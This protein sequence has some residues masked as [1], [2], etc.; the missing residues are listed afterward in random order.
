MGR[1]RRAES[2]PRVVTPTDQETPMT[3]NRKMHVL[4]ATCFLSIVAVNLVATWV[5]NSSAHP[6]TPNPSASSEVMIVATVLSIHIP[7]PQEPIDASQ[8]TLEP[9]LCWV[10]KAAVNRRVRGGDFVPD[11]TLNLLVHS[12]SQAF[13]VSH[14]GQVFEAHLD[15]TS[16]PVDYLVSPGRSVDPSRLPDTQHR[17][18][19]IAMFHP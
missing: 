5:V 17:R 10:V 2:V 16:K 6:V 7:N 11:K 19:S 12:P 9:R 8:D 13:G 4:V 18:F 14:A 15:R 3:T 1:T